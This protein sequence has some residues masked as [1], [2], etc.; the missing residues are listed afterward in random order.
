MTQS[1][2]RVRFAPSP[3]GH[4]HIGN[5]RAALINYLFARQHGGSFLLRIED[6]DQQRNIEQGL[7]GILKDLSWCGLQ[8]DEEIVMQS[9]RQDVYLKALSQLIDDGKVYKCF[10]TPEELE[11]LRAEQ[12]AAGL[13]PRYDGR[14]KKLLE[15]DEKRFTAE[16][17]SFVWRFARDENQQFEVPT[18]REP[19]AFDMA[20]FY[21]FPITRADGSFTFLF[22]N[23][24]DDIEMGITHVIRGADHQSNTGLQAALYAGLG[25]ELPVFIH[26]PL[27]CG[28]D[29][30]KLSKRDFG[31]SLRDLQQSG[32]VPQ[33][34]MHYLFT[35]GGTT[36]DRPLTHDELLAHPVDVR[37]G[38]TGHITYDLDALHAVMRL[39]MHT[40]SSDDLFKIFTFYT[41]EVIEPAQEYSHDVA[42]ILPA[43]AG[44]VHNI[45]ELRT[46]LDRVLTKPTLCA[47]TLIAHCGGQREQA[48]AILNA[49]YE[50][51][52]AHDALTAFNHFKAWAK[53]EGVPFKMA[54][55]SVRY[56]LVGVL[57]GVGV[58]TLMQVMDAAQCAQ[59]VA[60]LHD[61]L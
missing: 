24:V 15:A 3:T 53:K 35:A 17:R 29:G 61:L 16:G 20:H 60:R 47:K 21:D 5:V 39:Y 48:M 34:L 2:V 31:F 54:L 18:L 43:L 12:V 13:P 55:G 40:L 52:A 6:T 38:S 1:A 10:A 46:L 36:I 56:A 58:G 42:S 57:M 50:Q 59:R 33:A 51:F 9:Q 27:L 19:L 30:K 14:G 25:A 41:Q 7:A 4:M 11:Q 26:L 22:T 23:A 32:I 8:H 49:A 44:E 37:L 45:V 28:S